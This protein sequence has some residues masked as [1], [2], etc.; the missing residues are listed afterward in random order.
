MLYNTV[1]SLQ[2]FRAFMHYHIKAA[3]ANMHSR[4]RTRVDSLLA[5]GC[6][7]S[8]S[9]CHCVLLLLLRPRLHA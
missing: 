1:S 4:M 8:M 6:A 3:K 9:C 2:G 7:A 5:G